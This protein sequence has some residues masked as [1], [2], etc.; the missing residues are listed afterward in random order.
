MQNTF[1]RILLKNDYN[2]FGRLDVI[3]L[4]PKISFRVVLSANEDQLWSDADNEIQLY[5]I[6][7]SIMSTVRRTLG[8]YQCQDAH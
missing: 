7:R 4:Y 1:A 6:S 5:N 3:L 8:M 2:L